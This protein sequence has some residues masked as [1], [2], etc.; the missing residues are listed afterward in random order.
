LKPRT[1][2]G[3]LP[4]FFDRFNR[5]MNPPSLGDELIHSMTYECHHPERVWIFHLV[6]KR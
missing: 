6:S 1:G 5:A 2:D 4:A 3:G